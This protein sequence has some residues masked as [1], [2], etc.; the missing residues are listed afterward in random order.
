ML[1]RRRFLTSTAVAPAVMRAQPR[2]GRRPNFVL[3]YADDLG[4][5]DLS[6]FRAAAHRTTRL[7]RMAGEGA[8]FTDFYAPMPYCAPSRAALLTGRYQFRSGMVFNP[9]PDGGIN[10]IG[11]PAAEVTIAEALKPAGYAS[12]CIGKWHLGHAEKFLPRTQG[13][14]EYYGILYSNDMRPV[15]I[16]H[17]EK[18]EEY[19]VVQSR[20]T[21]GYTDR[22]IRFIEQNRERPFFVYLPHAM[23]HKPL[24]ASEDHYTPETPGDLYSDVIRELDHNVGRLLDAL[25]ALGLDDN[26][27][28][29]FSS[30]NGPW[31]GGSTAGL[32][33]MKGSS[34]EGGIRVPM[35]ARW[36]GRIPAGRTC[37]EIAGVIDVLPTFCRLAGVAPPADRVIDGRD[38]WPLMT[39][40]GSKT[41][42]E[43]LYS[44]SAAQLQTIRSGKWKLHVRRPAP[45]FA[46]MD[47]EAAKR[48][49]DQRGPDGVTLLAQHE[50]ARPNQYPGTQSGDP[51][52]EMMLFDLEADRAEQRDVAAANPEVVARLKALFDKMDAQVPRD[53]RLER[54]G[55]GGGLLR[56]KGGSLRYDQRPK[57]PAQD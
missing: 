9:A 45:G 44:M 53:L 4:Y 24:A 11:L 10:D 57:P 12:I 5:G 47:D 22:A 2:S 17:N 26:T 46:H 35:I 42:H 30:D 33:G 43:A 31:F 56:L 20:L 49:V 51:P 14:D 55:S 28:V 8:R 37:G 13:F 27:L 7:D 21:G 38:I 29:L 16:V 54:H 50:Q 1:T 52:K 6:S 25:K 40:A 48:W 36:P 23:P 39:D 15:Q 32:R 41:P 3:I 19:P 18:V 34:W